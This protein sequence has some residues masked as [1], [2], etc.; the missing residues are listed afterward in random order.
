MLLWGFEPVGS[1]LFDFTI[2]RTTFEQN[3]NVFEG[4]RDDSV[5]LLLAL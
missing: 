3:M 1:E 2:Q 5:H 4:A